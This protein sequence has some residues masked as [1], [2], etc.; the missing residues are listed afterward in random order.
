M[1]YQANT[2]VVH[3]YKMKKEGNSYGKGEEPLEY[4]LTFVRRHIRLE[5]MQQDLYEVDTISKVNRLLYEDAISGVNTYETARDVLK[6]WNLLGIVNVYK[7]RE[8]NVNSLPLA[9]DRYSPN[10]QGI[11][12]VV[13]RNQARCINYWAPN[14]YG[15]TTRLTTKYMTLFLLLKKI[16]VSETERLAY[17]AKKEARLNQ[18]YQDAIDSSKPKPSN[19]LN[20]LSDDEDEEE[21]KVSSAAAVGD[22]KNV[23]LHRRDDDDIVQEIHSRRTKRRKRDNTN[24]HLGIRMQWAFVPYASAS[25]APPPFSLYTNGVEGWVGEYIY[26]GKNH[27]I[28]HRQ[29]NEETDSLL[30]K[31]VFPKSP[32]EG[33]D[34]IKHIQHIHVDLFP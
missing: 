11:V 14:P 22:E 6:E 5:K 4:Q 20:A 31:F 23:P 13:V 27:W 30:H 10:A 9:G 33:M 12:N 24:E 28:S 3:E 26:L 21:V 25:D 29:V 2:P 16:P 17:Q 1:S 32:G 18:S 15:N 19:G 7:P 34:R 8:S